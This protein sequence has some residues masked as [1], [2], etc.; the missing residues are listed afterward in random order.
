M[1]SLSVAYGRSR[2]GTVAHSVCALAVAP[3]LVS[4]RGREIEPFRQTVG[5]CEIVSASGIEKEH[6]VLGQ[7]LEAGMSGCEFHDTVTRRIRSA[8][9]CPALPLARGHTKQRLRAATSR[10]SDK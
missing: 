4:L 9:P 3:D 7:F 10:R 5:F 2:S 8:L 6:D 1:S